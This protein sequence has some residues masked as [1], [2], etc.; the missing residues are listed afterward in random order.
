MLPLENRIALITGASH[1]I[2]KAI[3]LACADAGADV[4]FTYLGDRRGADITAELIGAKGRRAHLMHAELSDPEQARRVAHEALEVY[5]D[6]DVLVNNVGGGRLGDLSSLPL[7]DWRHVLDL[8]VTAPLLTSQ[9]V[10]QHMIARARKAA[11]INISSVHSTHVWS[12]RAAYGVAKAALNRLTMSMGLEWAPHGI[13]ANAIAP[14]YINTAETP[15][16]RARYDATDG[17]SAPLLA[18]GRTAHPSEI[19][20][21]AVFL[22]SDAAS[23]ITGQ[24]IFADGGLLLPPITSADFIRSD[25]TDPDLVG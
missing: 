3:A 16:E 2:G 1:G 10:V 6:V 15:E 4:A 22:A 7:D 20:S 19:A 24:T 8:N 18:A 21:L 9:V 17:K 13:R 25:R 12:G 23:Y 14:G 11:V 5:G